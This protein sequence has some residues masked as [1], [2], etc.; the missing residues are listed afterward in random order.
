MS[1]APSEKRRHAVAKRCAKL[2]RD[3][4]T[5]SQ[6]AEATGVDRDVLHSRIQLGE[7]LLSLE[8]QS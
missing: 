2:K 6:I 5:H 4:L 7:R 1:G 3:G 8:R